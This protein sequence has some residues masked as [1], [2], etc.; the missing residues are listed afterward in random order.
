MSVGP[1]TI[2]RNVI[3]GEERP[4]A[5]RRHV[6]EAR[7]GDG[8][9]ALDGRA[10]GSAT[11]VDAAIAA[12]R[13]GAA[14][15]GGAHPVEERGRI[16]RAD[17]A[18]ARARPRA[19]SPRSSPPRPA[20]R[21][22][23][24]AGEIDGAIELGYFIAGEGRRFYGR[25][26]PSAVAEPPGDDDPPAARRRRADHRREHADR[27]RRLEGLSG[28]PLRQRRRAEGVRGHAR[29]AGAL[30]AARA[31]RP[32][33]RRACSTSST[34]S[35][36]RPGQ[37]LVEDPRVAVVSLHRLDRGRPAD[38]AR[39]PASGSPRSAS[40]SAAR[41]RSSSATTPTSSRRRETAALSAFSNAGQR[42]AAGSRLIVFDAVYD[43]FRELLLERTRAQRV[44]PTDEH[45][46]GPVINERQL[47][48]MLDAVERARAAG[49]TVLTGGER[50][51]GPD[52]D[53]GFYIAP[54]IV[55]DVAADAEI[56]RDGALRPDHDAASRRAT[57]RRRSRSR[58][59]SPYG[60]TAA[61]WTSSIHRGQGVRR[62]DRRRRRPGERADLRLRAARPLRRPA[63]LGHRLA[64]ARHRG[65]R[66]LLRLEDGLRHPR[67]RR[68]LMGAV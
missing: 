13:R 60:L 1:R 22:R 3:G 53:G 35:A 59:T 7:A 52:Y 32:A 8:R 58:T 27:E 66:R 68:R 51:T 2:S 54:T 39:R 65:A 34:A 37:P 10:L 9:G 18:A 16:L 14:G 30:R 63:R 19:R 55:E 25:T 56:S 48:N 61:I 67:P 4:A 62:P 47:E 50:L 45:D 43:R 44:G 11:D 64:R 38:R 5:Q 24:R 41:T 33:C 12:A 26:M 28:A 57:S 23:T 29:D 46:F 20:S 31:R 40:S 49:A 36:R 15:V 6:R 17:R 21:R 42:C